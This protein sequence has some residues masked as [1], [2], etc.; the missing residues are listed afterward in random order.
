MGLY[1]Y[2][3]CVP[4]WCGQGTVFCYVLFFLRTWVPN[5][6]APL[7]AVKTMGTWDWKFFTVVTEGYCP[8][9]WTSCSLI[10]LCI[11]RCPV[12][13]PFFSHRFSS[14]FRHIHICTES[15]WQSHCPVICLYTRNNSDICM[16]LHEFLYWQI[17]RKN[18]R[19]FLVLVHIWQ[20]NDTLSEDLFD[21]SPCICM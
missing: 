21:R 17:L 8:W 11:F 2:S 5:E 20:T 3:T 10:I 18:W 6:N 14:L 9:D 15:L 12:L 7:H 4:S 19:A 13:Y 16:N 1:L